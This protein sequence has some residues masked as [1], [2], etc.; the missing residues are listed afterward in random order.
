MT[1][2][3]LYTANDLNGWKGNISNLDIKNIIDKSLAE[4]VNGNWSKKN[5]SREL[6]ILQKIASENK[7]D[8][9]YNKKLS[10]Y[11]RNTKKK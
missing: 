9:F 10:S 4:L 6:A 11:R 8:D 1:A 3:F 5:L 2:D 7:L